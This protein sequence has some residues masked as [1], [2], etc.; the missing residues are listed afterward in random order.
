MQDTTVKIGKRGDKEEGKRRELEREG[1]DRRE[2]R[3]DM[4]SE[5]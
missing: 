2:D 5:E 3:K 4:R 1:R